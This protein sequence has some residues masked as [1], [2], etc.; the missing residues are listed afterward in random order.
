MKAEI[1]TIGDEI[2]IGQIVDTNSAW[3]ATELNNIGVKI[4]Q[5]TSISDDPTH[6]VEAINQAKTRADV[7]LIT[8][9]L[10]PTK[11]DLTKKVL[12]KYFNSTLV[13]HQP[14]LDHVTEFFKRRGKEMTQLNIDQA[15]VPECCEVLFNANGTAPG[16]WF[17]DQSKYIVSMPGVP[18]EMKGLMKDSVLPK[19]AKLNG[20]Q[21]IVHKT[22]LTIGIGESFLA[23]Q[24]EDWEN[25]LPTFIKLAYL[26]APG[27]VRL[28]LSAMG[29][30]TEFLQK[31]VDQEVEK[32]KTYIADAIYGYG[33]QNLAGVV[34]ELLIN[35]ES[36]LATAES[37]TGG[38]IAK[39]ITA[40]SGSSKYFKGSIV[41]YA[42]EI[43]ENVLGV[44][45]S[46]LE[47]FGAVSE[48]V[49]KQ[50]AIG[51][52]KLFK[53]DYAIATS[54]IAGPDGGTNEK[55]VGTVWMAIA[56]PTSVFA[57]KINY[58]NKRDLNII[59]S[60]Q[61]ALNLLRLELVNK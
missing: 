46:D 15:L 6:I 34:G 2:L 59:R 44:N 3:M 33:E 53:T 14:T 45:I 28:R 19:L 12:A 1:I 40:N 35:N 37:C 43:K 26:P 7:I 51:V 54:G 11:D 47:A 22:V 38:N 36:T 55:P 10:G 9:G 23:E 58:A 49:V 39:S 42:N 16:M 20:I 60:S 21:K 48:P 25:N 4:A 61:D 31:T 18:F 8:G 17:N 24:I 41:A 32:L 5:I 52:Q 56:T 13:M 50:M 27:Q 57:K 29:D 30:N